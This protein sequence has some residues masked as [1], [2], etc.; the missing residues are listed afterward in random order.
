MHKMTKK[1]STIRSL[2]HQWL[3][4]YRNKLVAIYGGE[5]T[6]WLAEVLQGPFFEMPITNTIYRTP[7]LEDLLGIQFI[8]SYSCDFEQFEFINISCQFSEQE[9]CANLLT[10]A[11][12]D[13]ISRLYERSGEQ[14][15]FGFYEE[16]L[17]GSEEY[18]S[19]GGPAID[20]TRGL[21]EP[22][23]NLF[24]K[25]EIRS[26]LDLPFGNF[27]WVKNLL[28]DEKT[29]LSRDIINDTA[30]E[31][32]NKYQSDNVSFSQID[33][34]K[35]SLPAVD[36]IFCRDCLVHISYDDINQAIKN[37]AKTNAK[38]LITTKFVKRQN[39]TDIVLGNWR[40]LNLLTK[41]FNFLQALEVLLEG[42]TE[43]DGA[44]DDKALCV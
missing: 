35:D 22:L 41:L 3:N 7:S 12:A 20:Q 2:W 19:G 16:N 31:N 17:R 18:I 10:V 43:S 13:K 40:P 38:Y 37:I 32:N 28:I 1:K 21:I 27:N 25:L 8:S 24:K 23:L 15:I 36:A 29:Y 9:S 30:V 39:N 11:N 42:C 33:L 34:L 4:T 44:Y 6:L 26:M 5:H 14:V